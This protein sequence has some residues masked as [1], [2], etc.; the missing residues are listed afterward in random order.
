MNQSMCNVKPHFVDGVVGCDFGGVFDVGKPMDID[1]RQVD[2][3]ID[4]LRAF[5]MEYL[6]RMVDSNG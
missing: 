6:K 3:R 4:G 5:S 1:W 2:A